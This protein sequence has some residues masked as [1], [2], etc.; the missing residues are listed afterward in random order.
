[1]SRL[2]HKV[3]EAQLTNDAPA[4]VLEDIKKPKRGTKLSAGHDFFAPFGFSLDKGEEIK[5]PTGIKA[6]MEDNEA[7]VIMPRSS[8]GFKYYVRLANTLGLIDADYINGKNEGHIW[9]KIR[10]ES[11]QSL[12][13]EKGEAFAQGVFI[14]YL[15]VDDDD[16]KDERVGG[17]GSTN[18]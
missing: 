5:I 1:M 10:N 11:D 4:L 9:I 18:D 13:I 17:I 3:S 2:F 8:L 6:E 15:V 14:N 7:L 16:V 12:V